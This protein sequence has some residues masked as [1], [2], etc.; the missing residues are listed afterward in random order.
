MNLSAAKAP[1]PS[2][3]NERRM[4]RDAAMMPPK[5]EKLGDSVPSFQ[6]LQMKYRKDVSKLGDDHEKL[7]E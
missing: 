2:S 7:I 3:Q 4:Q 5:K 6:K 1:L